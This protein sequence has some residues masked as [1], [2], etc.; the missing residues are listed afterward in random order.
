MIKERE[1]QGN[2]EL[3]KNTNE[4]PNAYVK[5]NFKGQNGIKDKQ[6]SKHNFERIVN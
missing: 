6:T 2:I 4:Q 3:Q 5:D 1:L